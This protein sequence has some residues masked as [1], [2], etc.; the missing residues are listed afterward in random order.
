MKIH[1]NKDFLVNLQCEIFKYFL[2]HNHL[3]FTPKPRKTYQYL[4]KTDF[5]DSNH[6]LQN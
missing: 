1:I 3:Y 5:S 6:V 2:L 4:I